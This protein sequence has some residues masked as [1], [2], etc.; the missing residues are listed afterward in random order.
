MVYRPFFQAIALVVAIGGIASLFGKSRR[1]NLRIN[2]NDRRQLSLLDPKTVELRHPGPTPTV[3]A[4]DAA[5]TNNANNWGMMTMP[6]QTFF[7][8]HASNDK[9]C[10]T[11]Q[12]I[13]DLSQSIRNLLSNGIRVFPRNGFLLGIIRHG[14]FLPQEHFDAD[15]GVI[16]SDL[17]K[18]K[19]P[20]KMAFR[21]A[22]CAFKMKK[23][24]DYWVNWNGLDPVSRRPYDFFGMNVHCGEY[25]LHLNAVYPYRDTGAFFY[26]WL[27]VDRF[28]HEAE[29]KNSFRYNMEGGDARLVDTD[30]RLSHSNYQ[31]GV[32]MIR[33]C[34]LS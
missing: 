1:N 34:H 22:G 2:N 21:A 14:G 25:N 9:H 16:Y 13:I 4:S 23:T 11:R 18:H 19:R 26:P 32:S 20:P 3:V 12:E 24:E 28:N 7:P 6:D 29:L 30:E 10:V 15:L 8:F 27:S 5:I 17:D 33:R 31:V